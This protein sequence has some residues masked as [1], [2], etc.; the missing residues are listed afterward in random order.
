MAADLSLVASGG[1]EP[2]SGDLSQEYRSRRLLQ[3]G[4]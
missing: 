2:G 1:F 3:F 4:G